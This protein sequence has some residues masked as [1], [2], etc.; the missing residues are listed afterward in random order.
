[1]PTVSIIVPCFN[2]QSTILLLLEA[3]YAQTYPRAELEVIVAD[4]C[5]TDSTCAEIEAFRAAHADLALKVVENPLRIIPAALN[6]ALAASAGKYI[7][8]LDAHSVPQVDYVARC[9]AA[10]ELGRATNVGGVWDIRPGGPGWVA[11]AIAA[12]AAHPLGV[13][14]AQYRY[15]SQAGPVDTVPFGS[16]ARALV[17]RIGPFDETLLTNEDYEFNTRIRQGGGVVWL[18]PQI[19]STYFARST[20]GGL[21]RQYWRYGYWKRRMLRR[22][23]GSLRWRQALPPLFVLSLICL[24]LTGIFVTQA[25]WLLGGELIVYLIVELSAGLLAA[26]RRR[27]A[28]MA[29]GLP[30]GIAT[31]HI[32]WGAGFLWSLLSLKKR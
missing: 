1:M 7:V 18:D 10:L 28:A 21:A 15:A 31:M 29:F 13:G 3:V 32:T 30:L 14:D 16:F 12:A 23:P 9:V 27:D 6:R 11:R 24:G 25:R 22:Y 2:E 17:D 4:G 5:S 8:R 20:L 19:R 26:I